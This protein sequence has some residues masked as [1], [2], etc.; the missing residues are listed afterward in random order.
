MHVKLLL[1]VNVQRIGVTAA[2]SPSTLAIYC[3]QALQLPAP[4]LPHFSPP[5]A[6]YI[7][8]GGVSWDPSSQKTMAADDEHPLATHHLL[9]STEA[10]V[11][12]QITFSL[13]NL[14]ALTLAGAAV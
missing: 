4:G 11:E 10:G 1:Q 5:C 2:C 9:V 12:G 14:E 7:W 6:K 8:G 13:Q 3:K